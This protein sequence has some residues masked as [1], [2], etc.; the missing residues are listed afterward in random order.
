M[1]P[2]LSSNPSSLWRRIE[3]TP[4]AWSVSFQSRGM[5]RVKS[6]S[7]CCHAFSTC[8]AIW[9]DV[10]HLSWKVNLPRLL[11]LYDQASC[12]CPARTGDE[13]RCTVHGQ[14]KGVLRRGTDLDDTDLDCILLD[15]GYLQMRNHQTTCVFSTTAACSALKRLGLYQVLPGTPHSAAIE[16]IRKGVLMVSWC[17]LS[18]RASSC[19]A[20]STL[21]GTAKLTKTTLHSKHSLLML[22]LLHLTSATK[23]STS[24]LF[25]TLWAALLGN[26]WYVIAGTGL[27]M[28]QLRLWILCRFA[29]LLIS[30]FFRSFVVRALGVKWVH[31]PNKGKLNV[32][33]KSW[34]GVATLQPVKFPLPSFAISSKGPMGAPRSRRHCLRAPRGSC[35]PE[36]LEP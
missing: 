32:W 21:H 12:P 18:Y 3:T 4:V 13:A 6:Q 2:S 35:L 31:S 5:T 1:S 34:A 16:Q 26:Y 10:K 20:W 15:L 23:A 14:V 24:A 30:T 27:P 29:S 11:N 36:A 33:A 19:W 25:A 7:I 8:V 28:V 9:R 17:F 22:V